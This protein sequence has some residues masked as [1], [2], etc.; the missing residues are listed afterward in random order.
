[1]SNFTLHI[2]NSNPII[3]RQPEP[4]VIIRQYSTVPGYYTNQIGYP[5]QTSNYTGHF[6][7]TSIPII[8]GLSEAEL[9][10]CNVAIHGR[11]VRKNSPV[12]SYGNGTYIETVCDGCNTHGLT[13]FVNLGD[14]DLCMKCMDVYSKKY[15]NFTGHA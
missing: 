6:L 4:A 14:K 12:L 2:M 8:G 1:M 11:L 9:E 15:H 7:S 10:L 5:I 13:T 3:F